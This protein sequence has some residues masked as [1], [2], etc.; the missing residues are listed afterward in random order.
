[1]PNNPLDAEQLLEQL[2]GILPVESGVKLACPQAALAALS[3]TILARLG[4]RL[5][6]VGGQNP[7]QPQPEEEAQTPHPLPLGWDSAGP[8]LYTFGYRHQQSSLEF[9]VKLVKVAARILVTASA[10]EHNRTAVWEVATGDFTSP[11]FFP[12]PHEGGSEANRVA[13]GF[14]SLHRVQDY[15]G[16]FNAR[17]VQHILPGLQKEGYQAPASEAPPEDSSRG[18]QSP[19]QP[20]RRQFS[21]PTPVQPSVPPLFSD[22]DD[23]T[24]PG[25]PFAPIGIGQR[26]LDPFAAN[27]LPLPGR[28]GPFGG[29]FA[30]P[31]LFG[32]RGGGGMLVGPDDP[33]FRNRFPPSAPPGAGLPPG[34]VPPGAN[35]DPIFPGGPRLPQG[36]GS[37]PGRGGRGPLGGDPDFDEFPPPRNSDYDNM[38]G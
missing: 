7:V 27:P 12:Y 22:P 33:L 19:S 30:P 20:P 15:A 9:V 29:S 38:F 17:I 35:F 10:T 13:D 2:N 21:R 1:M 24:L 31:P 34:A 26:D 28:N 14:I 8:D 18:Q 11:S 6:N 32:G 4:F 23:P 25:P 3:H 16:E 37:G 36:P 5:I